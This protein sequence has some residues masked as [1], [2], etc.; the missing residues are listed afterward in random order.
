LIDFAGG[1]LHFLVLIKSAVPFIKFNYHKWQHAGINIFFTVTTILLVLK[2]LV[3][4]SFLNCWTT[5]NN[6]GLLHWFSIKI[7]VM[8]G[9]F[10]SPRILIGAYLYNE[11]A[12]CRILIHHTD[13]LI[14]VTTLLIV[15]I[16]VKV[17]CGLFYEIVF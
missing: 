10:V 8:P 14:A 16:Q 5:E 7:K 6:F 13:T 1:R 17:S 3:L 2:A 9:W 4:L 15:T 12:W 11:H